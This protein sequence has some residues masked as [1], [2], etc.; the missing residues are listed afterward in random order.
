MPFATL[1]QNSRQVDLAEITTDVITA[2]ALLNPMRALLV[3][4]SGID[5]AGKGVVAAQL[6]NAL[7]SCGLNVALISVD[8]WHAPG[9][10]RFGG[11]GA[12][13]R[14]YRSALRLDEM[15]A[16]LVEPMRRTG[17][18]DVTVELYHPRSDASRRRAFSY[19]DID[20]IVLEGIYLF[21][22][23]LRGRYDLRYWVS[24]PWQTAL[25]RAVARR[26]EGVSDW[27]TLREYQTLYF[28]AQRHH[29]EQD[30][31]TESVDGI[32]FNH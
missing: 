10:Q 3:A 5:G 32:Y 25:H 6:R 27:E 30:R 28:P 17:A 11:A 23:E 13:E 7:V 16:Q 29:L 24:C 1:T 15:L 18:V 2:R 22:T 9:A 31:P 19:R 8:D 26:Q 20:I 12:A 4:I 14:F 21:K